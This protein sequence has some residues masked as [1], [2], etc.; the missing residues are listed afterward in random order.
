MM[1]RG[2]P[3][4]FTPELASLICGRLASGESLR[5]ICQSDDI[6]AKSTILGWVVDNREGFSDQYARARKIQAEDLADEI[7]AVADDGS[8]DW[9]ETKFGPM[10]NAENINRSRLRVD[11]RK[12]Y[13]SKVLPKIYGDKLAL[14]HSVDATLA[15]K[16]AKARLRE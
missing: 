1:E 8:N 16:I 14:E 11:T 3:S 5:S 7:F 9:Q 10:V 4:E 13:L 15:D 6:P 2:R 12:W